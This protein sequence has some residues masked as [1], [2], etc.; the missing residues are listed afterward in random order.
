MFFFELFT[1]LSENS[2]KKSFEYFSPKFTK[3]VYFLT[4]FK[5]LKKKIYLGTFFVKFE[6]S[7]FLI[8]LT[9]YAKG[10]VK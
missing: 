10:V 2:K 7:T 9:F 8:F 6:K 5:N 4:L 3:I 1:F